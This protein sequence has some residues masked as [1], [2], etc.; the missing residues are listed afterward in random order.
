MENIQ[1]QIGGQIQNAN[2]ELQKQLGIMNPEM[3]AQAESINGQLCAAGS[4]FVQVAAGLALLAAG[5]GA[6]TLVAVKCAPN[7]DDLAPKDQS[8]N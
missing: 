3:A 8:S 1:K 5:I 4:D 6:I 2:T 7:N